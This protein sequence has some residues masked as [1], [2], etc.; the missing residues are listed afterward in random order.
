MCVASCSRSTS[1]QLAGSG[2][3]LF[4]IPEQPS[5]WDF[6]AT[7]RRRGGA[8]GAPNRPPLRLVPPLRVLVALSFAAQALSTGTDKATKFL[9]FREIDTRIPVCPQS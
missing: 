9:C 6:V 4:L 1:S 8:G 3:M 2:A 5:V 7:A